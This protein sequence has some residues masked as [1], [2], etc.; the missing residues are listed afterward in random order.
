MSPYYN[1]RLISVAEE[2]L[3]N[4]CFYCKIMSYTLNI[5]KAIIPQSKSN[6][7]DLKEGGKKGEWLRTKCNCIHVWECDS[8]MHYFG[9]C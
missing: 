2:S 5:T 4:A 7:F 9:C 1:C 8:E 6:S 3:H